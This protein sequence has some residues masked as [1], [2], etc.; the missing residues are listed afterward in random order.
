MNEYTNKQN[1]HFLNLTYAH[2]TSP[3]QRKPVCLQNY[4]SRSRYIQVI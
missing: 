1:N 2:Q 4:H 3:Q